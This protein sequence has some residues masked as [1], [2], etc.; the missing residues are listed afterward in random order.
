MTPGSKV[1]TKRDIAYA[2]V[3]IPRGTPG[4]VVEVM[5]GGW[6]WVWF[7]VP[8][9]PRSGGAV[10]PAEVDPVDEPRPHSGA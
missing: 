10:M 9:R 2:T 8:G 5:Q 7:D 4:T 3:L 1:R 6:L